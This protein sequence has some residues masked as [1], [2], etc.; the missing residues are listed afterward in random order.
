MKIS[1]LLSLIVVSVVGLVGFQS[2]KNEVEIFAPQ[3]DVTVIYG[4]LNSD[5]TV[6]QFKI[7]RVFQGADAV[8]NLAKDPT[9]SE[10]EN[11]SARLF[12]L[13]GDGFGNFDTTNQWTLS[14][15]TITDKDSGYF[16]YPNQKIYEVTANLN[17]HR[18][19]A[20]MVDK[21]DGSPIVESTTELIRVNGDIL[22]K[23]FGLNFLGLSLAGSNGPIEK[24]GLE[25]K[26]PVNA[27]VIDVYLDFSWKDEFYSGATPIHHTISYKVGTY[28]ATN[29]PTLDTDAEIIKAD[30]NPTAFYEFIAAN[31]SVV[32]NGSDLKQRVADD[33]PLNFRFVTGGDEF[34][35]YLEV[36]SPSTSLLETKPE[37]TNVTNGV[38]LFSCRSFNNKTALM[39]K[40]SIV[41]LVDGE[42]M[43]GRRFCNYSNSTD[44]N[45]CF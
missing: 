22:I 30:L 41:Y 33:E 12:E 19:Y 3:N 28:L 11:I 39:S 40:K 17:N 24:I 7:N 1:V 2:C 13:L 5:D 44:P 18:E 15:R 42:I 26:M 31:T 36:A 34:N 23:P 38:G 27:K 14:E 16:Y 43:A 4:L 35:T 25:L 9:L 10:Y 21:L 8:A 37:Y 20:V 29:I 6:H 32:P 45:Y